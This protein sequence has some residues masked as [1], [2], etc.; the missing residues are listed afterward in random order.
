M[1]PATIQVTEWTD[2]TR[3]KG[4]M[5]VSTMHCNRLSAVVQQPALGQAHIVPRSAGYGTAMGGAREGGG[6]EGWGARGVQQWGLL[7]R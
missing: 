5:K 3:S 4:W 1:G 6:G 2:E 7:Q